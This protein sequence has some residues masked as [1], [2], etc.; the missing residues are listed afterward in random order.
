MLHYS[1]TGSPDGETV[2]FLHAVGIDSSMWTPF[3]PLLL[4]VRAVLIDLPG[5]GGS[6]DVPWVSL[7]EAARQVADV[8]RHVGAEGA[9]VVAISL[10]SYVGLTLLSQHPTLFRTAFL[11][12]IHAGGMKRRW[13]MRLTSL[14]LAP[15]ATRPFF[16]RKT[17]AMFGASSDEVDRFVVGAGKTRPAAFRS[18]TNDVVDFRLPP[19]LDLIETRV[20]FVAGSKEHELILDSLPLLAQRLPNARYEHVEG[21][22]HGWPGSAPDEFAR[23]LRTLMSSAA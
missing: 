20:V 2:V 17:A 23:R 13:M 5:H 3:L 15:I 11:S 12:G 7:E 6:R 21:G 9:H 10:G 14:I 8:V 16:A 1:S 18:A 22:N 19:D 4:G